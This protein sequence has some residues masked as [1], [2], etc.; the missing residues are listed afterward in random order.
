KLSPGKIVSYEEGNSRGLAANWFFA[1][2]NS[3]EKLLQYATAIGK[4][5]PKLESS[6]GRMV[7]ATIAGET[8]VGYFVS[9][10]TVL[11]QLPKAEAVLGWGMM[12]DGTPTLLRAMAVTKKA[13]AP[14]SAKLLLDFTL[15]QPGQAA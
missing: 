9:A 1:K 12:S 14:N 8:M 11:P 4:A 3:Q 13:K 6:G 5:K 10:I 7:D 15:S 2:K